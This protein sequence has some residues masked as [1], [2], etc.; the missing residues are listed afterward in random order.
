MNSFKYFF[1][2]EENAVFSNKP[3]QFCFSGKDCL[4]GVYF[5]DP[6]VETIC[7]KCLKQKKAS[8]PIPQYVRRQIK[9]DEPLKT[10]V[11]MQTP[12]VPWVQYNDWPA[13]CDDYMQYVGEWTKD[14]FLKEANDG[15]GI[16]LLRTLLRSD[17][18]AQT[19]DFD[20]LWDSIG[21]DTIV[22]VFRCL[23]C[24]KLTAVCQSY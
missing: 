7:L 16:R 9:Q 2:V 3:C 6:D 10:T 19:E 13:C 23:I 1:N 11:L 12:P 14:T 8:V 22:F 24:G 15:D 18:L 20:A 5:D 21:D 4:D 17:Q